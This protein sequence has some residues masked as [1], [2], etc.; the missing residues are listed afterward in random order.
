LTT[1]DDDHV[2]GRRVR[3]VIMGKRI[4]ISTQRWYM[5]D[6]HEFRF[7]QFLSRASFMVEKS[8]ESNTQLT[9]TIVAADLAQTAYIPP[10]QRVLPS[11]RHSVQRWT[12]TCDSWEAC[13]Q[14]FDA[15][16]AAD[17]YAMLSQTPFP[18]PET[19]ET[20]EPPR[21]CYII[22]AVGSSA[23]RR[24][25]TMVFLLDTMDVRYLSSTSAALVLIP[26]FSHVWYGNALRTKPE[27]ESIAAIRQT[28]TLLLETVCTQTQRRHV[29]KVTDLHTEA[30][31]MSLFSQ[32]ND[33][34]RV[35]IDDAQVVCE[36]LV[37]NWEQGGVRERFV[38]ASGRRIAYSLLNGSEVY[39][40]SLKWQRSGTD[41]QLRV[42]R[43]WV[44]I[45][46]Q[47]ASRPGCSRAILNAMLT[48][49]AKHVVYQGHESA[50]F[51][52]FV[53]E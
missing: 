41:A 28:M 32:N 45:G 9:I 44:W 26:S 42:Q 22:A 35:R 48:P 7:E 20:S 30:T 21:R 34:A 16:H 19:T 8:M 53:C 2:F 10:H 13:Q 36:R 1:T 6:P 49:H 39:L 50:Y 25:Q 38:V 40:I 18:A 15:F 14:W 31:V 47:V 3:I 17:P 52:K 24:R 37:V 51:L 4:L 5:E 12:L 46:E 29:L 33:D 23:G 43:S 27:S 11:G